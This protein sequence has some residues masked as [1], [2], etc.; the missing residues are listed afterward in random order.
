L[1]NKIAKDIHRTIP[2]SKDF[3]QKWDSGENRLY[4]ILK[5]YSSYDSEIGYSQGMNFIA[6]VLL[7]FIPGDEDAFWALVFVMFE[8]GWRDIF[9][10]QSNKI[11]MILHDLEHYIKTSWPKLYDRF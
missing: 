1:D 8:R 6:V 11:A 2:G 4:N 5:A 10:Q 3:S 7:S 9:N